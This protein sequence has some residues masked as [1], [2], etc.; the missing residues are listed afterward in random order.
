M[1]N[2]ITRVFVDEKEILLLGTAHVSRESVLLVEKTIK[3]EKPDFV[4]VELCSDRYHALI[5]KKRWEESDIIEIIK[6]G[7]TN[8]FLMQLLLTNFQRKIGDEFGVRPGAEMLQAIEIAKK[9]NA[10]IA[11]V[12]RDVNVTLSRAFNLM[13]LREKFKLLY[14]F[15]SGIFIKEEITEETIEKFKDSDVI[16]EMMN[17]L[18]REIPSVKKVL[19]DERDAYIAKKI[20]SLRGKKIL[21]VVGAGHV[22]GIK[23]NLEKKKIDFSLKEI[24]KVPKKKS[25]L[26]LFTYAITLLIFSLFAFSFYSHG[27]NFT[28]DLF[29][30]WFLIHA[31]LSAIGA[32]LALAHPIAIMVAFFAAPFT[33]LHPA[34]A[35]GWFAGF[36]ELWLRKPKVRDFEGLYK[37]NGFRDLWKNQVTRILLVISFSNIGSSLGTFIAG[38][39]MI[40]ILYNDILNLF[41]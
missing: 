41:T 36:A 29:S 15:L 39:L 4:A 1:L 11:L 3:E 28:F 31:F 33:S 17:E 38:A 20:L 19:V 35:S 16:T 14:L 23:E 12:D 24:R 26:K 30:K 10:K 37:I 6:E 32:A 8:L 5:D 18:G 40:K 27:L 9:E 22:K 25:A 7:K 13:S 34:L 21:A 2:E